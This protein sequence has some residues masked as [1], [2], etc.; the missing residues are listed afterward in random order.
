MANGYADSRDKARKK[1]RDEKFAAKKLEA[2]LQEIAELTG[3]P[4][5][6]LRKNP[7]LRPLDW[8][9]P[10][11]IKEEETIDELK[12]DSNDEDSIEG[13]SEESK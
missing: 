3:M 10:R 8:E 5:E 9:D 12:E 1:V 11:E 13:D 4:I 2:E 6:L 7:S